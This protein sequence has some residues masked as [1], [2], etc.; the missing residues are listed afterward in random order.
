VV[1]PL[2]QKAFQQSRIDDKLLPGEYRLRLRGPL[3]L[4][5]LGRTTAQEMASPDGGRR[6]VFWAPEALVKLAIPK[7][8]ALGAAMV[9]SLDQ[10]IDAESGRVSGIGAAIVMRRGIGSRDLCVITLGNLGSGLPHAAHRS[11]P[12]R[13]D[14]YQGRA[15]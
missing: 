9:R 13:G 11:P 12:V 14:E 2:G 7:K 1:N 10:V 5:Y 15:A 8:I 4:D 6:L 3:S